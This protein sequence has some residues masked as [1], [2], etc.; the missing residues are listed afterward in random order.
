MRNRIISDQI[1]DIRK[2]NKNIF[3]EISSNDKIKHVFVKLY[4]F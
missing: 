1:I 2:Q 3:I 4:K